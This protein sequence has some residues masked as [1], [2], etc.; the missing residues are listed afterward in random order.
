LIETYANGS[1]IPARVNR[2][3]H[4]GWEVQA[5]VVLDDG[6]VLTAHLTRD[7]FHDLNL[8]PQQKVFVR[9]RDARAFPLNY[10]I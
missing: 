8:Q 4:L 6:Q 2:V 1:T 3:I 10:S 9:P 7:R 5:E